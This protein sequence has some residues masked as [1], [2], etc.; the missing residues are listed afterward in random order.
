MLVSAALVLIAA[1]LAGLIP[2]AAPQAE[3]LG[4]EQ[5]QNAVIGG[6]A[7]AAAKHVFQSPYLGAIAVFLFLYTFGSTVIYFA[8]TD[9]IGAAYTDRTAR[10]EILARL[11]LT[12][13]LIT[14]FGQLFFTARAMRTFGLSFTIA[15]VPVVSILGFAALGL[16]SAGILPL[17][18]TIMVFGVARRVAEYMLT[19]PSR[20]VLFTVLSRE[21]KYKTTNFL[22]T[23][24]Y[25]GG[26]QLSGWAYAGLA[27]LGLTIAS[28]AWIAVPVSAAFLAVGLWLARQQRKMAGE[29]T[30]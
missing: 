22:E 25:R 16:T 26:D 23:F 28:I 27:G 10:T 17:L 29:A 14:A 4:A 30:T 8:Q 6:S 19:Q 12:T 7:F 24:V 15:A 20:K 13:Q 18:A 9:I 1:T 21:D 2:R 11:D 5:K 3:T